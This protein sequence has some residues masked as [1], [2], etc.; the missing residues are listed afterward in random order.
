MAKLHFPSCLVFVL[1]PL[2]ACAQ[3]AAVETQPEVQA[4]EAASPVFAD[5][6]WL[7]N[8]TIKLG[9]SPSV[10]RITWFG[11]A[12]GENLLW[13]NPEEVETP[14]DGDPASWV[15]Y[16]GDKPWVGPQNSWPYFL[17]HGN[18]WPP[19]GDV[20]GEPWTVFRT[21]ED[22]LSIISP[23]S[24]TFGVRLSRRIELNEQSTTASIHTHIIC[25][26]EGS[27]MPMQ[28]WNVTQ[29]LKPESVALAAAAVPG[30]PGGGV[31]M[32][33]GDKFDGELTELEGHTIWKDAGQPNGKKIGTIGSWI[34]S[35][36]GD[37]MFLQVAPYDEHGLYP[38]NSSVQL[39]VAD[40]YVELEL[41]SPA[42][43]IRPGVSLS[44]H[45][46]WALFPLDG[47]DDEAWQQGV[48]ELTSDKELE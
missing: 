36:H 32:V 22:T 14:P 29:V 17:P 44:H 24:S 9:V 42:V 16:G 47:P 37:T 39:Y 33:D 15:N 45:V 21:T 1:F 41:L 31:L 4:V 43:Q 6:V 28:L 13:I 12:D 2:T 35:K 10:G 19:D 48:L 5:T 38:E 11:Y 27:P 34:A 8:G 46:T 23:A 25:D 26:G 7:D 18:N 3:P 40:D 30:G 20:D